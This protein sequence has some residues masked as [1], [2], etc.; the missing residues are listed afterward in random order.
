[1][2]SNINY[3]AFNEYCFEI[4]ELYMGKYPLYYMPPTIHIILIQEAKIAKNSIIFIGQLSEETA[5]TRNKDI[6]K[7]HKENI[8][9]IYQ[10]ILISTSYHKFRPTCN[11]TIY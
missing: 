7:M 11:F 6:R 8:K 2:I 4:T 1:M 9:K 5:E 10:S 3:N